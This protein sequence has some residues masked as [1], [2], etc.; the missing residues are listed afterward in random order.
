MLVLSRRQN[1]KIVIPSLGITLEVL[2]LKG[3]SVKLGIAAP[4]E[5]KIL[6]HEVAGDAPAIAAKPSPTHATLAHVF[7]TLESMDRDWVAA[8]AF[9]PKNVPH[10]P[11]NSRLRALVV[12]DDRNE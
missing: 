3:N 8:H 5:V 7:E 6:R 1:E 2:G 12:E 4:P 9:A 10:A 11:A